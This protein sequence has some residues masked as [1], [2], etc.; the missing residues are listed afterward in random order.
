MKPDDQIL[1]MYN[2]RQVS[3]LEGGSDS[4]GGGL[5]AKLCPTLLTPWTVAMGSTCWSLLSMGFPRHE[6]WSGLPVL[7]PGD[8]S[9]LGSQKIGGQ[10]EMIHC[11]A[12]CRC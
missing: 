8:L 1:S 10:R 11:V 5:V 7:S 4:G 6:Y 2:L 9:N 3:H 12:L